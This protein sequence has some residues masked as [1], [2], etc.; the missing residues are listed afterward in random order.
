VPGSLGDPMT[1]RARRCR[2]AAVLAAMTA[3]LSPVVAVGGSTAAL[4]GTP[5][6]AHAPTYPV[7]VFDENEPSGLAPPA[8]WAMPGYSRTYVADFTRG[9]NPYLW[10]K[11]SGEPGGDPAGLFV[12]SHVKIVGGEL[13]LETYR[14]AADHRRWATGGVCLCGVPAT[15][16]AFFVR[17]RETRAGADDVEL[18]WPLAHGVW[19]PE[20]DIDEMGTS[21][22]SSSWTDHYTSPTQFVQ[23]TTTVRVRRWHTWGVVW[24]PS[25]VT[26]V[27]DGRVWGVVTAPEQIP[28]IPMTL[29]MQQQTWC[30][31]Y[32]ECPHHPS[33]MLIDWVAIFT[34]TH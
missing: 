17:S 15:Y 25:A 2:T 5:A 21:P 7:G 33:S 12:R 26:F 4:A 20:L 10:A 6:T 22:T 14:D 3:L 24:T 28:R 1:R 8:P 23:G 19:P 18:L 27:L 31:I 13:R 9:L 11:F 30:G 29:D 32:P 34:P 16:G